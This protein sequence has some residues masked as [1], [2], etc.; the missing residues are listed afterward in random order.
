MND[1][2]ETL[3]GSWEWDLKRLVTSV[4]IAAQELHAPRSAAQEMAASCAA[5]YRSA[6]HTFAGRDPLHIW[7]AHLTAPAAAAMG[8]VSTSGRRQARLGI[9][10]ARRRT[11][12]QAMSRLTVGGAGG[13]RFASDPPVLVPVRELL[14][15][16]DAARAGAEARQLYEEYQETLAEQHRDLLT[17]YELIDIA[18]KVVGVGSVDTRALVLLLLDKVGGQ[19]LILQRKEAGPSVLEADLHPSPYPSSAHRVVNGQRMMQAL[20]HVPRLECLTSGPPRLLLAS[21]ARH[22]GFCRPRDHEP[23]SPCHPRLPG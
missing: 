13:L 7:H 17:R 4:V 3:C 16:S 5:T 15:D 8:K 19:P 22:E 21:A 1:F 10:R 12:L 23:H 2:D 9:A 20:G 11:S 14:P 18:H 6:M